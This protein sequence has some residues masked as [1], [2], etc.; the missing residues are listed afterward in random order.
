L[1]RLSLTASV[2]AYRTH[3]TRPPGA[4]ASR[5]PSR[6]A[7]SD[8]LLNPTILVA[9]LLARYGWPQSAGP[10]GLRIALYIPWSALQTA[11]ES[12]PILVD[13]DLPA[14]TAL[15]MGELACGVPEVLGAHD[16]RRR[17]SG[18]PGL[19]PLRLEVPGGLGL[20]VA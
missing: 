2:L 16:V 7:R 8:L 17:V 1:P 9:L 18:N 15:R 10:I 14:D 6:H 3:D 20:A 19:V 5:A 4:S 13:R 11:R 12:V